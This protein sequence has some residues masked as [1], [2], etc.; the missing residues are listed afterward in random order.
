MSPT[1]SAAMLR[2]LAQVLQASADAAPG[3]HEIV[4][5]CAWAARATLMLLLAAQALERVEPPPS[6][7]VPMTLAGPLAFWAGL[8]VGWILWGL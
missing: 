5:P 8:T 7:A 4:L 1:E 2:H 3:A 6:L